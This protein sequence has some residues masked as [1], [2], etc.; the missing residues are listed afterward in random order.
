M[1]P[2]NSIGNRASSPS[3]Q[4]DQANGEVKG[5][6]QPDTT[7]E[8]QNLSTSVKPDKGGWLSTVK[9]RLGLGPQGDTFILGSA[10]GRGEF[11]GK[12]PGLQEGDFVRL[13]ERFKD[14]SV[15]N[16]VT[17]RAHGLGQD[18]RNA[19]LDLTNIMLVDQGNGLVAIQPRNPD[20]ATSEPAACFEVMNLRTEESA[21]VEVDG[22]GRMPSGN[23][24]PG[25]PGDTFAITVTDGTNIG[26][27]GRITLPGSVPQVDLPDPRIHATF[28]DG[29][30]IKPLLK[31]FFG[32]IFVNG[33]AVTDGEQGYLGDCYIGAAGGAVAHFRPDVLRKAMKDNGNGT[34][35]VTFKRLDPRLRTWVA[36]QVTVDRDLYI[37]RSGFPLYGRSDGDKS[38]AGMEMWFPILEKAWAQWKGGDFNK[39]GN[40]GQAHEVM[41]A[42]LG[43]P[44]ANLTIKGAEEHAWNVLSKAVSRKEPLCAGTLPETSAALYTNTGI[45][46]DHAYTVM[47]CEQE[48]SGQRWVQLRNP[49]GHTEPSG[50]GK[51]DGIFRLKWEE[52]TRLFMNLHHLL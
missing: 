14:G 1:P 34:V 19:P 45:H 6:A 24:V 50:D 8:A 16:W 20:K 25:Q 2:V 21:L 44:S 13:R 31:R 17:V 46:A 27:V 40:G 47:G 38:S 48:A 30:I 4:G 51:D 18:T 26:E 23:M 39:V 37:R 36:E 43:R 29:N 3:V 41:G 35:T 12:M 28:N 5:T 33:P 52:F 9:D 10:D 22:E 32:P 15:G 11:T 42:L 7:I 49:W